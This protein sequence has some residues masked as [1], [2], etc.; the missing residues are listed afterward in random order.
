MN[1]EALNLFEDTVKQD[2]G[3]IF[4]EPFCNFFGID[5]RNQ[6]K[7]IQKNEFLARS[8]SKKTQ[9]LLFGDKRERLVFQKEGFLV[10][11]LQIKPQ[12]VHPNLTEKLKIFQS[13]ILV[14]LTG[15]VK[16]QEA[17][18]KL[19]NQYYLEKDNLINERKSINA[20][21][22]DLDVK[23]KEIATKGSPVVHELPFPNQSIN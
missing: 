3:H 21:I 14:F 6:K 12:I 2:E 7:I 20:R 9:M 4:I 18:R 8:V 13:N 5:Y 1:L 11:V 16:N 22:K 23:I 15:N 17:D 19:V 10:W